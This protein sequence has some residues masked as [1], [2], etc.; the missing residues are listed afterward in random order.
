MARKMMKTPKVTGRAVGTGVGA[1]VGYL[2][3]G[4]AGGTVGGTAGGAAAGWLIGENGEQRGGDPSAPGYDFAGAA[5]QAQAA[6]NLGPEFFATYLEAGG[7]QAVHPTVWQQMVQQHALKQE[8][9]KQTTKINEYFTNPALAKTTD[10]YL[11][12]QQQDALGELAD[13]NRGATRAAAFSHAARGTRGSSMEAE[14]VATL[15]NTQAQGVAQTVAT[16]ERAGQQLK[17]QRDRTRAELIEL[18]NSASPDS[19]RQLASRFAGLESAGRFDAERGQVDDQF[20][21]LRRQTGESYASILGG[22]LRSGAGAVRA[23]GLGQPD[24][25]EPA[26]PRTR[27]YRA[28]TTN[29]S[30]GTYL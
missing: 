25:D 23:S 24:E 21:Q 30:R 5:L 10:T 11:S 17:T 29:T 22:S 19:A 9:L 28:P 3:G 14:N 6:R 12:Q 16:R 18:V 26:P 1:G 27:T 20:D 4:P 2:Y 7:G 13:L 15:R 8:R